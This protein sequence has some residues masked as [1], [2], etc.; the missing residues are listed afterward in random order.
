MLQL[1]GYGVR[2]LR[3]LEDTGIVDLKPITILVGKNSAGKSTFARVM[4]LLKQSV[5][6]RKQSPLLWFGRLVDFGSF[7]DAVSSFA[8]KKNIELLLRFES[9]TGLFTNRDER[10]SFS[11]SDGD[12][13]IEPTKIDV[14]IK[15]GSVEDENRTIWEDITLSIG[16]HSFTIKRSGSAEASLFV[17]GRQV[18]LPQGTSLVWS[19]SLI[20]PST[21]LFSNDSKN[22][23]LQYGL[24]VGA[25]LGAEGA[26]TAIGK[27]VHGNTLR[28]KK[29]EI[30]ERLPITSSNATLIR[31]CK[32]L[33]AAPDSWKNTFIHD[34]YYEWDIRRLMSALIVYKFDRIIDA[35]E[36]SILAF[37]A[38]ITYLE[39]LRATAQRYYRQEEVSIDELDP[40][41]LNTAFYFQGLSVREKDLLNA[42]LK[43][44]FGFTLS[45]RTSSGHVTLNVA[46][47]SDDEARNL[48]DVGLGYSQLI[49]VAIQ[50][51]AATRNA[52]SKQG[53]IRT[54]GIH[55]RSR[56]W[57]STVV[58]EQPELH[59]HPAYQAQLARV[60]AEVAKSDSTAN[61]RT[62]IKIVAETHSVNLVNKLGELIGSGQ[63]QSE[64]VQVLIFDQE[65]SSKGSTRL[66]IATFDKDGILQNWPIGFFDY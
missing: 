30:A 47:S 46:S 58:V 11:P 20:F 23:V 62:S 49:P 44:A 10:P 45:L 38:G 1:T 34:N 2:N 64:D 21:R 16:S 18:L 29:E 48:A 52:A 27:F 42:W 4:P 56:F 51:W 5:E 13:P 22:S 53:F 54:R 3:A 55:V 41:G 50:L 63:L 17:D 12:S 65:H 28:D 36:D 35:L 60:F 32:N 43:N 66:Q 7:D 19:Q 15:L 57:S 31:Y 40:K 6:R 25:K 37:C 9:Q 14:S 39:P 8:D 61:L 33:P 26:F 59:L 24:T